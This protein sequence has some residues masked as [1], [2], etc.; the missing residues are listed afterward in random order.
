MSAVHGRETI[1]KTAVTDRRY[2]GLLAF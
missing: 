2:S 1:K